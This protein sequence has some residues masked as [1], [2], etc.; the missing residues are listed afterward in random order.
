[1]K[2]W[3]NR[4]ASTVGMA[5]GIVLL[6]AGIAQAA[7]DAI[8]AQSPV[9]G[10]SSGAGLGQ[11]DPTGLV[12]GLSGSPL[13]LPNPAT[14]VTDGLLGA[15]APHHG[16]GKH[17]E[18]GM[19]DAFTG[20]SSG[21]AQGFTHGL[22]VAG[23]V[24]TLRSLPAGAS[25]LSEI[26]STDVVADLIR[27]QDVLDQTTESGPLPLGPGLPVGGL[28][29][30]AANVVDGVTS[31]LPAKDLVG[32]LPV[33]GGLAPQVTAPVKHK[34]K[35]GAPMVSDTTNTLGE[36]KAAPAP[37][38]GA[39]LL[40]GLP[41]VG[42]LTGGGL[43]VVGGL[44]VGGMVPTESGATDLLGGLPVV[45]GLTG[46]GLPGSAALQAVPGLGATEKGGQATDL[47]GGLPLVGE[48]LGGT[49]SVLPGDVASLGSLGG[50]A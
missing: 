15:P 16:K 47:I 25:D 18:A 24:P 2:K 31:G 22:P 39:D 48:Q 27:V 13:G 5:G 49:S 19:T 3:L 21:L 42:G 28:D 10:L 37:V 29:T 44:P 23:E 9:P 11:L 35:A 32:G 20:M 34:V 26:N 14:G 12:G 46:S 4:T 38:P 41:L 33:V 50:I 7:D 8:V 43:P 6:A 45:G 17:K 1:M 30:S 36:R 40:G